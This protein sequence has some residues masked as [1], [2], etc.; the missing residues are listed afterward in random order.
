M[1]DPL[2]GTVMVVDAV[3]PELT[4]TIPTFV[5]SMVKVTVPVGMAELEPLGVMVA[6]NNRE[7][8]AVGVVVAG[9]KVTV[10]DALTTLIETGAEV[11]L[12]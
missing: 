5:P 7:L 1:C 2:A 11:A 3:V 10:V 8:P 12:K 4:A 9:V 6:V